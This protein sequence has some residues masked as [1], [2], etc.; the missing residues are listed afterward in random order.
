MPVITLTI[1]YKYIHKFEY[2]CNYLLFSRTIP[3]EPRLFL[4][5]FTRAP[6]S[7]IIIALYI[8]SIVCQVIYNCCIF[9]VNA[10]YL[11]GSPKRN[12]NFKYLNSI[13]GLQ[14]MLSIFKF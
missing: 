2:Y 8:K 11:V 4:G 13:V 5:G 9:Y 3:S 12:R 7:A 10:L 14:N 6:I 1:I